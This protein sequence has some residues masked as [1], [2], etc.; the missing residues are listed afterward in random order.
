MRRLSALY[1][2][3]KLAHE[4]A[5]QSGGVSYLSALVSHGRRR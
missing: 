1:G 4:E 2:A 3:D 5:V